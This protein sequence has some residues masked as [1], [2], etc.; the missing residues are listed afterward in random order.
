[1]TEPY[2]YLHLRLA[3][4]D[5]TFDYK[6]PGIVVRG[7]LQRPPRDRAQHAENLRQNLDQA[8]MA[9][10]ARGLTEADSL[11]LTYE[12]QPHALSVVDSLEHTRRGIQLLSVVRLADKIRAVILVSPGKRRIL[13]AVLERYAKELHPKSGRPRNQDLV[14]NIEGPHLGLLFRGVPDARS[15][16]LV[17]TAYWHTSPG[18]ELSLF[19][20]FRWGAVSLLD[21]H[22]HD[23]W[24]WY[25]LNREPR[26]ASTGRPSVPR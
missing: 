24:Q 21:A 6:Y 25:S 23:D 9:A 15:H 4:R 26:C 13:D 11:P 12:L 18:D 3:G 8:Q 20:S 22:P 17:P 14:E 7:E 10:T 19:E 1:M 16:K 5:Q 2:E